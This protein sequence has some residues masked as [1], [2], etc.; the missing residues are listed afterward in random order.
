[1]TQEYESENIIGKFA[2]TNY[3]SNIIK[4]LTLTSPTKVV[5]IDTDLVDFDT[6]KNSMT[7]KET[8]EDVFTDDAS[9]IAL[10]SNPTSFSSNESAEEYYNGLV[11]TFDPEK[12]KS[13]SLLGSGSYGTVVLAKYESRHYAIKKLAKSRIH[14]QQ[15]PQILTEKRLLSMLD[16]PFILRLYGTTQT[17]DELYFVTEALEHGDLFTAIY[18]GDRL[19]HEACVFYGAGIILGLDF[20]HSKGVVYRDLKPENIMI[21]ANGY[22]RIID[23]GLAKQL[24]YTM[25]ENGVERTYTQCYTLCGTPEYLAPELILSKPYDY[26]VDVWALG[27]LLYEM[28]F[29]RT[30]FSEPDKT[31]D[32]VT[33]VF[34]NIVLCGKNGIVLSKQ[35]DKRT[36]GTS[37]A[38]HMIT[39]LLSGDKTKRL[40]QNNLPGVLLNYPYYKS[41]GICFDEL[42]NQT[43]PPP[44]MQPQYIG[45]DIEEARPVEEYMGNQNNFLEF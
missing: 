14:E 30:P 32:Y 37:N 15:I 43:A 20:I 36:D 33:K 44:I 18:D 12:F 11:N 34:T 24:P 35:T 28:I 38:R 40:G 21:G 10:S 6:T 5:P 22:P 4:L 17:R 7:D 19:S 26:S 42:Y 1:M 29:R 45:R 41:T 2:K 16:D 31:G 13:I 8:C 9:T 25:V 23:F 27:A 39:K 3:F